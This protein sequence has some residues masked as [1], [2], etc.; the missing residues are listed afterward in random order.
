MARRLMM[1]TALI[2]GLVVASLL[3]AGCTSFFGVDVA[4]KPS[5]S[6]SVEVT[7]KYNGFKSVTMSDLKITFYKNGQVI[8]P[9][10]YPTGYD[11]YG[12]FQ[13]DLPAGTYV[14]NYEFGTLPDK[15]TYNDGGTIKTVDIK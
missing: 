5:S 13:G 8:R 7:I 9:S 11:K 10:T 15:L 2:T 6:H 14:G 1:T 12:V 3:V 4:A